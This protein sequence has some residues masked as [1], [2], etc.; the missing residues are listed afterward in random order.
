ML[1]SINQI[2][3]ISRAFFSFIHKKGSGDFEFEYYINNDDKVIINGNKYIEITYED[4]GDW[5]SF[6][7]PYSEEDIT[8]N[9]N[10]LIVNINEIDYECAELLKKVA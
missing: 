1:L 9:I 10:E 2:N 5:D 6:I 8:I 4:I 3:E 7:A